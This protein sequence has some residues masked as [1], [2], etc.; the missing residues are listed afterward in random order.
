MVFLH[1]PIIKYIKSV[2]WPG[3]KS[4]VQPVLFNS[5]WQIGDGNKVNFWLDN[6]IDQP[7]MDFLKIP[8]ILHKCLN[9]SVADLKDNEGWLIPVPLLSKFSDLRI[10]LSNIEVPK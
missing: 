8:V 7:L 1:K 10:N 5:I 3:I 6:W 4:N 2:I 9:A